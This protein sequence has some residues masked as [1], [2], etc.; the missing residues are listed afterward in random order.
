MFLHLIHLLLLVIVLLLSGGLSS[1][2]SNSQ[3]AP[4][5]RKDIDIERGTGLQEIEIE[6]D[7]VASGLLNWL[8]S[9]KETIINLEVKNDGAGNLGLHAA[10][11]FT[12]KGD[13]VL[14]FSKK[15]FLVT[16]D[17]ISGKRREKDAMAALLVERG[18]ERKL[19]NFLLLYAVLCDFQNQSSSFQPYYA[20]LPSTLP[21]LP[22]FWSQ[23]DMQAL[24]PGKT[25]DICMYMHDTCMHTI[26][27]IIQYY[28]ILLH[29]TITQYYTIYLQYT[30]NTPKYMDMMYIYIYIYAHARIGYYSTAI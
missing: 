7:G 30:R 5:V 16:S 25:A 21:H 6:R 26:H 2:C 23:E 1:S 14:K 24:G 18:L 13:V 17:I 29:N 10:R 22:I 15:N 19:E 12:K 20:T 4:T 28:T 8:R 11:D 27:N 9:D 3:H